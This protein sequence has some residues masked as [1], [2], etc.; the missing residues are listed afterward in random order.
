MSSHLIDFL[1]DISVNVQTRDEFTRNPE[2]VLDRAGMSKSEKEA[3]LS[4]DPE[5]IRIAAAA[6]AA[7]GMNQ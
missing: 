5:R 6:S 1:I 7:G 4:G 2:S 3:V